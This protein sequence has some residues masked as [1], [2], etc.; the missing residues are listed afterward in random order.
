MNH[1]SDVVFIHAHAKGIGGADDINLSRNET[2]ENVFFC[3]CLQPP[4]KMTDGQRPGHLFRV[5][6]ER[7]GQELR[8]FFGIF[9][10]R[11]INDTRTILRQTFD[12]Q[13]GHPAILSC[14]GR[15]MNFIGKV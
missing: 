3:R 8:Q 5:L 6:I 11:T 1:Q 7:L 4:V 12:N 2:V 14:M 13:F 9:P 10:G 15:Q